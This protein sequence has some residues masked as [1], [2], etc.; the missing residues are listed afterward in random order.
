MGREEAS[1]AGEEEA[2]FPLE[3]T[4]EG[5]EREKEREEKEEREEEKEERE[6]E[7]EEREEKALARLSK[8]EMQRRQL[9]V[10]RSRIRLKAAETV[11]EGEVEA[12][13]LLALAAGVLGL[14]QLSRV[15]TALSRGR[16]A[17][18]AQAALSL[19]SLPRHLERKGSWPG[20]RGW[21]F[22]DPPLEKA[23]AAGQARL[24]LE[25]SKAALGAPLFL[26]SLVPVAFEAWGAEDP[27]TER[28]LVLLNEKAVPSPAP[29]HPGADPGPEALR[30]MARL[31]VR[32]P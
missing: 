8:K 31:R 21:T 3:E 28:L 13:I 25:V 24:V 22:M 19:L 15:E 11:V 27:R 4:P 10:L 5:E 30:P 18:L 32:S 1:P 23:V 12:G 2:L 26:A 7:K 20:G 14:P 6:E 29:P 17:A 16:E 9:Q